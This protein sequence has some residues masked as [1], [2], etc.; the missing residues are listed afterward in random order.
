[1]KAPISFKIVVASVIGVAVLV[2]GWF[3]MPF[4]KVDRL[5]D[6]VRAQL[7]M[8][9]SDLESYSAQ[10]KKPYPASM[11]DLKELVTARFSSMPL[12]DNW[13]H[14]LRYRCENDPC[15]TAVLWSVGPNGVDEGGKGDD[16]AVPLKETRA[17]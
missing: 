1:M 5:E 10:E 11:K 17:Q 4:N 16:I 14:D 7:Q 6:R 2:L 12:Q 9:A 3:A 8:I 13:S 15:S